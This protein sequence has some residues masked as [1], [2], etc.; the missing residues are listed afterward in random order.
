MSLSLYLYQPQVITSSHH[1]QSNYLQSQ[2]IG[3]AITYSQRPTVR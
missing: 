1:L 2:T 3:K